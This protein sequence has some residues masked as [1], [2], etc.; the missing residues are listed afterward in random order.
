MIIYPSGLIYYL[1]LSQKQTYTRKSDNL[2]ISNL[3]HMQ[4][5]ADYLKRKVTIIERQ[6]TSYVEKAYEVRTDNFESKVK[7]FEYLNKF[8]LF[9]YKYYDQLNIEK[10]HQIVVNKDHLTIEGK[11]IIVL[12][13]MILI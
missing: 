9:G 8:P 5:I 3:P 13:N 11:N 2:N 10:I 1:R 7:L 6:K 12:L 4:L